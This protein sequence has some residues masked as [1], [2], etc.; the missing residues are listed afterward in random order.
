MPRAEPVREFTPEPN[1]LELRA[2]EYLKRWAPSGSP[3]PEPLTSEGREEIRSLE[4]R[5]VGWALAA[6]V[7]SGGLIGGLEL[8]VRRELMNGAEGMDWQAQ[9]PYWAGF[10][11]V[12]GLISAVE[13]GFLY[14]NALRAVGKLARTGRVGLQGGGYPE[15]VGRGLAR[16]ALEFPNP[17][18]RVFG[19][20]PYARVPTWRLTLKNLLYKTKVGVSS[21]ILRVSLRRVVGRMAVRGLIPLLA[22][23]L[24]AIWNAFI[25][26]KLLEAAR[27][28]ALAP[29]AMEDRVRAVEEEE[30]GSEAA[31]I[32]LDG[33]AELTIRAMDA[34]PNYVYLVGRLLEALDMEE[35]REVDWSASRERLGTLEA[36]E[37]DVV[38]DTLVVAA[39]L[40]GRMRD[41]QV[42]F[43]EEAHQ[44]A[45]L[46]FRGE[47]L[48]TLRSQMKAGQ[49]LAVEDLR[50]VRETPADP[51]S[52]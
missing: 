44:A 22:A 14:W 29:L 32:L 10:F 6:G 12:A 8:F 17:G 34:H 28:R 50:S 27:I 31:G 7:V 4:R 39:L 43:L 3:E 35:V 30:L 36:R 46:P 5:V 42:E 51:A 19:V 41:A 15:L 24:Y 26:W 9:A 40:A 13:I 23:P 48:S 25:T 47:P 45:D 11:V 37:R 49:R 2:E 20:D 38:L 16:A 18:T 1:T 33:V 52:G 21:F